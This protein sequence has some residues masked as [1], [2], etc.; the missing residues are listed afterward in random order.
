MAVLHTDRHPL[1]FDALE[2][3]DRIEIEQLEKILLTNRE[4]PRFG[5]RCAGLCKRIERELRHRGYIIT[6][7]IERG[8]VL[9]CTD[10]DASEYNRKRFQRHRR[11]LVRSHTR[12]LAVDR[13]NL[14]AEQDKLHEEAILFEA[15]LLGAIREKAKELRLK[16]P[17]RQTPGLLATPPESGIGAK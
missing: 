1:D 17:K 12:N 5:L 15:A 9:I 8:A 10:A 16:P 2:K 13:R 4:S 7:R 11:G 14:A 3:G 6:V